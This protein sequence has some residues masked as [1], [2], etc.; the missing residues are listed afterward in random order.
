MV[1]LRVIC[2]DGKH[3]PGADRQR[4]G[5]IVMQS[6]PERKHDLQKVYRARGHQRQAADAREDEER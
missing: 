5:V 1:I 6:Q 3:R 4:R 2:C